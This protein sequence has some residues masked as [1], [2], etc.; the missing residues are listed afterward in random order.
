RFRV[1]I[2]V[3]FAFAIRAHVFRWHQPGIM[4]ERPQLATEM[5][6]A[7]AGLHADQA[8]RQVGE[9][10]FHLATRPLLPQHQGSTAILADQMERVLAD[11]DADDG[12]F[13]IEFLGHGVL[14]C[15]RCPSPAWPTGRAGARPDHPIS[16]IDLPLD[17][18]TLYPK[19]RSE[20]EYC[21]E[22]SD[23]RHL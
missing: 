18:H 6:C 16:C 12:D 2:I 3:L 22:Q 19:R 9:P 20:W 4:A 7:D 5:M 13:T 15:P 17:R 21:H 1:A 14:L 8:R 11:I 23:H 10:G